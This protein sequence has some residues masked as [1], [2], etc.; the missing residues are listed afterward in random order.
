MLVEAHAAARREGWSATDDAAL[1][2]QAGGT[3][4]IVDGSPRNLKVTT[5][6]DL[7]FAEYLATRVG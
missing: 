4:R 3:V 5:A 1:V 6:E 2:E 7:E